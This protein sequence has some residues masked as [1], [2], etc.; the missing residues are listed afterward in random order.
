LKQL[1]CHGASLITPVGQ[2]PQR[3]GHSA[4]AAWQVKFLNYL[5]HLDIRNVFMTLAI[6]LQKIIFAAEAQGW[7][8]RHNGA[9]AELA[10]HCSEKQATRKYAVNSK[11]WCLDLTPNHPNNKSFRVTGASLI[12]LLAL[13]NITSH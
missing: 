10:K 12:A 7:S 13:D 3:L 2:I 4:Y 9:V 1:D 11:W 5:L 8:V 6:G